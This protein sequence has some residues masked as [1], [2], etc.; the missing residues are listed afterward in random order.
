MPPPLGSALTLADFFISRSSLHNIMQRCFC[1]VFPLRR[2]E[3]PLL[4]SNLVGRWLLPGVTC[5]RH[6]S[7][8]W[9]RVGLLLRAVPANHAR[10]D[11]TSNFL[12]KNTPLPP[13]PP[14]SQFHNF[15]DCRCRRCLNTSRYPGQRRRRCPNFI[16]QPQLPG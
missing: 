10:A 1:P 13:N 6:P 12:M 3:S 11:H 9:P 8:K 15:Q 5:S 4:S 14:P 2:T 7:P 16:E